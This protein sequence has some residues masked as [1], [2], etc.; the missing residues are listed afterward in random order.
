MLRLKDQF[1][2][3][4]R[5]DN[6]TLF[7]LPS[8]R[9]TWTRVGLHLLFWAWD[10]QSAY[11]ALDR[12]LRV[13][14]N[15]PPDPA[16]LRLMYT[17]HLGTT[18]ILFYIYGYLV[19]P[20]LLNT[21]VIH[22]ATGRLMWRKISFVAVASA[23]IFLIFNVYDYYLFTYAAE[24]F[25]PVPAYIQRYNDILLA[26]GPLGI[27]KNYSILTF[28]WGYN[29]SYLLLPLM[30]RII[31]EAIS[32]GVLSVE[33]KEQNQMLIQNQLQ[34]LQQQINP[35]F[36]FNVFN[37]IYSLIQ[38][39][40]TEAADL[41]RKLSQL[42]H[43][44]LYDTNHAFVALDGELQFLR[45]YVE[46]EQTRHFN[47]DRISFQQSGDP[48]NFQVPPLL[49]VTFIENAFKHGL[50][51]SFEAGWV[52]IEIAIDKQHQALQVTVTNSIFRENDENEQPGGV[53]LANARKRLN[54]L[55]DA[56]VYSLNVLE[57]STDYQVNLRIPLKPAKVHDYQAAY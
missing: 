41:L 39:S 32:W 36:L 47:P 30:L 22:R 28:L 17:T 9:V 44:T 3:Q 16:L 37:N 25:K 54:L 2:K 26:S 45:N 1:T 29:V 49:L 21:F 13:S 20:H 15:N 34:S 23:S 46:I 51:D 27:F 14:P 19:A 52:R 40:N 10:A 4:N 53:G 5:I 18:I 8:R 56:D 12:V 7:N 48:Q 31:R 43:Y 50:H 6:E 33:Q 42:M 24:Q 38:R 57:S 55:Y 35:H 11:T